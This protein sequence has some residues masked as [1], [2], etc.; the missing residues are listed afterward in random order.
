MAAI[1]EYRK[2]GGNFDDFSRIVR[3][4]IPLKR[5]EPQS[6]HKYIYRDKNTGHWIIQ[7]KPINWGTA[8]T[9]EKAIRLRNF[10]IYT[11]WDLDYKS[12]NICGTRK[13]TAAQWYLDMRANLY[14]NPDFIKW[15]N[16]H[17]EELET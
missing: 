1:D 17:E 14:R 2:Q 12:T 6:T 3:T 10:L 16:E 7:R 8:E 5:N 9:L 13:P 15:L 4:I 11:D